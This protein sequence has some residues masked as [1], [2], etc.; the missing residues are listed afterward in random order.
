MS[1]T[2][3]DRAVRFIIVISLLLTS[4]PPATVSA[5]PG[6]YPERQAGDETVTP[7]ATPTEPAP[8]ENPTEPDVTEEVTEEA[9]SPGATETAPPATSEPAATATTPVSPTATETVSAT[10]TVAPT[11]TAT[12]TPAPSLTPTLT[13][14]PSATVTATPTAGL[15]PTVTATATPTVILTPT[16]TAT[17]TPTATAT[18]APVE[19]HLHQAVNPAYVQPGGLV[20]VSLTL[21]NPGRVAV[22]QLVISATLPAALSY[23][24]AV[25]PV[26]PGY[27]PML[28]LL[29][30]R[31]PAELAAQPSLRV[32]YVAR[33]AAGTL[34]SALNLAAE[35]TGGAAAPEPPA[36]TGLIIVS[37]PTPAP[38]PVPAVSE[39]APTRVPAGPPAGVS[40]LVEPAHL[41]PG[42]TGTVL[43]YV[44]DAEGRAVADGSRVRLD[45]DSGRL[46][47]GRAD[48]RAGLV[49]VELTAGPRVGRGR[50]TVRVAGV[51]GEGT[52]VTGKAGEVVVGERTGGPDFD[53]AAVM[54]RVRNRLWPVAGGRWQ[55]ENERYAATWSDDG[56]ALSLKKE[57]PGGD[58][59]LAFRLIEIEVGGQQVYRARGQNAG[60]EVVGNEARYRRSPELV[61]SY[62]ARDSGVQQVF[63]LEDAPGRAGDLVIR[64]RLETPLKPELLSPEGGSRAAVSG[65]R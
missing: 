28:R 24:M 2:A 59:R 10:A 54:Q 11:L 56:V 37:L 51:S 39:P 15:T 57:D 14:E 16:A 32:G 38:S 43:V 26:T 8:T 5:R 53:P 42:Q 34:P 50:V 47:T 64:G 40:V 55:T 30:W 27:N 21:S 46:S 62:V 33:I 35:I 20:T 4:V 13:A 18:P 29:S 36:R 48:T 3:I 49:R 25:G 31:I 17:V 6:R 60:P 63:T 9:P 61:E 1:R 12:M 22:A 44:T 65:G 23:E 45:S 7:T 41:R 19:L 52:F 58:I